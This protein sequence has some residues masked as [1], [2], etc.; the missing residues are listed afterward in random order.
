[1]NRLSLM[2]RKTSPERRAGFTLTELMVSTF[3]TTLLVVAL[4]IIRT[5]MPESPAAFLA[6]I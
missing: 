6:L 2:L 1:M 4:L 5:I 3:V